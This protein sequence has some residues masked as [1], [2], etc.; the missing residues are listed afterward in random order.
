V[1]LGGGGRWILLEPAAGPLSDS[2]AAA[3][4]ELARR[5]FRSVIA[6]P[7]RHFDRDFES[8]LAQLVERDALV[9]VTAAM[10]EHEAP[11]I[12][13]LAR[14]GLVHLL[15]S[16]AHSSRAGRPIRLSGALAALRE[17][18]PL[19]PHL[20]WMARAAPTAILQGDDVEPPF[21]PSL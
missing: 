20:D 11:A 21:H 1:S 15:G 7:E 6:H 19:A 2:L 16:D 9:Q 4:D 14:R 18:E 8:R 13:D 12:L 17:V 5:G 10:L 3:V